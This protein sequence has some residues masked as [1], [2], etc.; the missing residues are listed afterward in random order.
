[1]KVFVFTLGTRGDVQPYVALGC[2]LKDAGHR[3]TLCTSSRFQEFVTDY[4]LEFGQFNDEFL[5]LIDSAAG[6]DAMENT[7]SFWEL[8]KTA[9]KLDRASARMQPLILE[10]GWKAAR[11]ADPDLVIFHPKAYGGLHFAEKL[12]VPA[13]LAMPVPGLV[14]TARD[15]AFGFPALRLGPTY[16]RL[17]YRLVLLFMRRNFGK[18]IEAW[19]RANGLPPQSPG[20]DLLH[21]QQGAP[22]PVLHA[23]SRH[24]APAPADWPEH[25]W[26][27]GYWML[28]RPATWQPPDGLLAFLKA[29]AAP[30]YVGFGSMAGQR[31]AHRTR[32]VMEALREARVRGVVATG[33]GGLAPAESQPNV[34]IM[35]DVPHDWLFPR[36]AAVVHH[37]GAGTTAAGLRAGRPSV[38]CPFFGDQPFWG[39][40]VQAL[41]AG[42]RPIPQK[43]L[44]VESLAAAIK[45]V[46]TNQTMRDSAENL[47]QLIRA[48][49]GVDTAVRILEQMQGGRK[50][51]EIRSGG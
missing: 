15:P 11:A 21:T 19:R 26:V 38:I 44:T 42:E 50:L 28:E 40:R 2:G 17:T 22:V 1:M 31:G 46:V 3:V 13:V 14:A 45:E 4:G 9:R 23:Y 35:A 37:G 20:R 8:I 18:H 30:V 7:A 12:G 24:V 16:N 32:L 25:V 47:G 10:D 51:H 5:K 6:Q 33:W 39:R 48:E 36:M 34:Y 41:G 43:R 49:K 27:T 29:G